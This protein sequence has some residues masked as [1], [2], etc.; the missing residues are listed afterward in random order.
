MVEQFYFI[1]VFN[2]FFIFAIHLRL[3]EQG[4]ATM[5]KYKEDVVEVKIP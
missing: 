2:F 4:S 5:S 1:K 3:I